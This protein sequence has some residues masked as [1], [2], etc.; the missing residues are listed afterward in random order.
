M[1]YDLG[2]VPFNEPFKQ[3]FNQGMVCKLSEKSGAVEKMSKSKGNVV[4]PDDIVQ[5]YGSDVLRMYILFM[6]PPELDCQWQDAG[7]DGI[8]RF[9]QRFIAYVTNGNHTKDKEDIE[10]SSRI[11]SFI[12]DFQERLDLFKPNTALASFMEWLN[13]M[14][15]MNAHMSKDS[16]EKVLVLYSVMAPH[17]AS[18]L[19]ETLLG[20]DL[21]ACNWPTYNQSFIQAKAIVIAVQVNGKLRGTIEIKG[22]E[23]QEDIVEKAKIAVEKWIAGKTLVKT[24]Y[25]PG[26]MVS[27]VIKD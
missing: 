2:H 17:A 8:K 13:D 3:L 16:L 20:K 5:I 15:A 23:L 21:A 12:K 25:I 10:V 22:N 6:G 9:A 24:V 14:G 19:V 26:K 1:L 11:H 18:E 27:L 7:I 4:N